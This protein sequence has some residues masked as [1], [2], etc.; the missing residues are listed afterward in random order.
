MSDQG[1]SGAAR[2]PSW[3]WPLLALPIVAGVGFWAYRTISIELRRN[4]ASVLETQL[5]ADAS[6]L[7]LWLQDQ[8]KLAEVMSADP[9]VR[10]DIVEM[11]AVSR[12]TGGDAAALLAAPAQARLRAI[13]APVVSRQQNAG[14]FV[15][16]PAGLI[17]ARIVDERVGERVAP[18]VAEAAARALGGETVFLPPTLK[19]RFAARAERVHAR[20]GARRRRRAPIGVFAFRIQPAAMAAM[21]NASSLGRS[22]ETYARRR[23]GPPRLREPLRGAGGGLGLLPAEAQ[24]HARRVADRARSRASAWAADRRRRRL[25]RPGR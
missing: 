11:L 23:R 13:L 4:V 25:Q 17:V 12:R 2:L 9:R 5:A 14:Y 8:G 10:D 19:Q 6:A 15:L 22:G 18:L 20:G 7:D 24:G 3:A 16:D 21:V 1:P